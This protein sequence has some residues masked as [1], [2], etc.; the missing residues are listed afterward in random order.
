MISPLVLLSAVFYG[1]FTA[2]FFI[3]EGPEFVE[4]VKQLPTWFIVLLM[5]LSCAGF[6]YFS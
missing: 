2:L 4:T 6:F 1:F 5:A 3:K